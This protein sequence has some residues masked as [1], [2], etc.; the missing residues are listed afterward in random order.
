M[1]KDRLWS[2]AQRY[3]ADGQSVAARIALEKLLQDEPGHIES[4]LILSNIAWMDDRTRDAVRHARQAESNLSNNGMLICDVAEA[5]LQVGETLAARNCLD[6]SA[7][8][9]THD[10]AVL[11]RAAALCVLLGEHAE[12]LAFFDRA[13]AVGVGD[14]DFHFQRGLELTVHGRLQEAEIEHQIALR[15]HPTFGRAALAVSRLR[16]QTPESNHLATLTERLEQVAPGTEDHIALEFATYKEMEDLGHYDDA[17]TAL[18][19][20]NAMKYALQPYDSRYAGELFKSLI[21]RCTPQLLQPESV[22]FDGPQP[23]FIIG[24]PRSG[25]TLLD[26]VMS[27]HSQV[28]S[29]GELDDFGRQLRLASN[30]RITLDEHVV[31]ALPGLDYKEIGRG[32]LAQTQWR[33]NGAG[34]YIDKLPRN[35][36]VAGLIRRALPQARILHLVREPMDV[37]FSNYRALLGEAFAYSYD[38]DALAAHYL[39]YRQVMAYW[40]STMQ[41]QILDV[42]YSELVR[43]PEYV[44]RRIFAFCGLEW[45]PGCVDL[46]RNKSVVATLSMAQVRESIH[47][48]SFQEWRPY[49]R[50]LMRLREAVAE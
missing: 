32:Y 14:A 10:G 34:F 46:S 18:A 2:R 49:E 1:S 20:G 23:I 30:H 50:K 19:R 42:S 25:T 7:L 38:L 16:K 3:R 26:R 4:H 40:H 13:G 22:H 15:K 37:C 45:E 11:V 33:A 5:L 35:W 24:M 8:A 21:T 48:R 27:N 47:T 41:G 17:W 36:M 12:A 39:Q 31:H 6:H 44:I 9:G 29:A 43:N 28:T